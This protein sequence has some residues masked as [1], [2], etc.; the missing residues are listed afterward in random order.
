M[1]GVFGFAGLRTASIDAVRTRLE[2]LLIRSERQRATHWT[3]TDCVLGVVH[4]AFAA[5]PLI[6]FDPDSGARLAFDGEIFDRGGSEER[7]T[8]SAGPGSGELSDAEVVLQ[9]YLRGETEALGKL[10]GGWSAAI[11]FENRNEVVLI[12]DRFGSRPLVYALTP[13]GLAFF[14]E[15]KGVLAFDDVPKRLDPA[16]VAQRFIFDHPVGEDTLVEGVK[17]VPAGGIVRFANGGVETSRY[18]TIQWPERY[19]L[20]K[21]EEWGDI[22]MRHLE[23]AVAMR[24][25]KTPRAGT[26]LSAGNDTRLIV[27]GLPK[28]GEP[29]HSFTFGHPMS[30]DRRYGRRVA[31][32]AGTIHHEATIDPDTYLGA[33][34][35][36]NWV[37]DGMAPPRHS[38]IAVLDPIMRPH[39]QAVLEGVPA[40]S[41]AFYR[42]DGFPGFEF[43]EPIDE[44]VYR[45]NHFGA[46]A[47]FHPDGFRAL[48]RS[49]WSAAADAPADT[50][51]ALLGHGFPTLVMNRSLEWSISQRLRRFS[52]TG[53]LFLREFVEVRQ[54]FYDYAL[55]DHAK[56][57][58]GSIYVDMKFM[59]RMIAR[60]AP[61]LAGIPL[62]KTGLPADPTLL[63]QF[64]SWRLVA[65]RQKITRI[66][67][68]RIELNRPTRT[69][70]WRPWLDGPFRARV[71]SVLRDERVSDR[72]LFR[73]EVVATILD[74]HFSGRKKQ[75]K[76]VWSL[77]G[78]E[79]W[80]R[81][82]FDGEW[83]RTMPGS[84]P[85]AGDTID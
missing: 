23:R 12:T 53:A 46:R 18:W 77:Y 40:A 49:P 57:I 52:N 20:M 9:L 56:T 78:F 29:V 13:W 7:L 84:K 3:G 44:D 50:H 74:D 11:V 41:Q 39:V 5:G 24:V 6:A 2:R 58:P 64:L 25:Q 33:V 19:D 16:G 37:C 27:A 35:Y 34:D 36:Y 65:A 10:N 72:G 85:A 45:K 15:V 42:Y 81:Q 54:P 51:R 14:P 4:H 38:Q 75:G 1:A 62:H 17:L 48:M 82:F 67:G 70:D 79:L 63:Q 71:E 22:Y 28:D 68:G 32:A 30:R 59:H 83:E 26:T 55:F 69:F 8:S 21:E 60:S 73:P 66:T 76:L 43:L 31:K 47:E 80:C 61:H